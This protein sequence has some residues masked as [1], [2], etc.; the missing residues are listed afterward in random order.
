MTIDGETT[1]RLTRAK[2][3]T[4]MDGP[5]GNDSFEPTRTILN[6]WTMCQI[7]LLY[8]DLN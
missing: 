5:E 7:R 8:H 1:S 6:T 2:V 3:T 4:N